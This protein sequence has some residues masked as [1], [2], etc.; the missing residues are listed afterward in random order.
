MFPLDNIS[1]PDGTAGNTVQFDGGAA[2]APNVKTGGSTTRNSGSKGIGVTNDA[3][4][5]APLG[6][7]IDRLRVCVR[8]YVR[9]SSVSWFGKPGRHVCLSVGTVTYINLNFKN[10]TFYV[11]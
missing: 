8:T 10:T 6:A 1:L 7:C 3:F 4:V 5:K 11:S 2:A 9:R